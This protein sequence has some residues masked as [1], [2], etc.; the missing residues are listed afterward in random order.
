MERRRQ[1]VDSEALPEDERARWIDTELSPS[2]F[3][4]Y[5]ESEERRLLEERR[6]FAYLAIVFASVFATA[7]IAMVSATALSLFWS[8]V[9]ISGISVASWFYVL[10]Y[11]SYREAFLFG[12]LRLEILTGRLRSPLMAL[13]RW[14]DVQ[15]SAWRT[16]PLMRKLTLLA[17]RQYSPWP[18]KGDEDD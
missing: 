4:H 2:D 8:L 14:E 3:L 1:P 9:A 12:H 13:R 6:F 15:N 10:A 7:V 18:I 17:Y 11:Y 5:F 16:S